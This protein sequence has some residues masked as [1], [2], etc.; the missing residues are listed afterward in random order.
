MRKGLFALISVPCLAWEW[1]DFTT[2]LYFRNP[3]Q[4]SGVLI[5]EIDKINCHRRHNDDTASN[6]E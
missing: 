4:A 2:F 5:V 3:K 1:A 6:D